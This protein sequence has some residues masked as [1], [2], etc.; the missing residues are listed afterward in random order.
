MVSKHVGRRQGR[1]RGEPALAQNQP[2]AGAERR[3]SAGP[4]STEELLRR[5]RQRGTTSLRDRFVE[6]HRGIVESI[7]FQFAT[8]LPPSVDAQ[9]LVHA[10]MWGLMQA[11]D[12]YQPDR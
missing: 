7:A 6:R 2:Q 1:M 5:Y 10:G 12:Y 9:D 3:S 4:D 8:R 11:I